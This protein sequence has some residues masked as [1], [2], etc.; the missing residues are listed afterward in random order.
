[1]DCIKIRWRQYFA[2]LDID[3]KKWD[4]ANKFNESDLCWQNPWVE[5]TVDALGRKIRIFWQDNIT[6]ECRGHFYVEGLL[7]YEDILDIDEKGASF[8]I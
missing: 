7:K 2:Y 8:E 1:V 6:E 5:E 4:F 3:G